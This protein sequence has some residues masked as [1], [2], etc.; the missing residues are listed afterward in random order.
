MPNIAKWRQ[1]P[2]VEFEQ[3]VKESKS[4]YELAEKIGYAKT[5]GGTQASLKKAVQERGLDTSHFTGQAW[6]KGQF[7][8]SSFQ[9]GTIKKN[10]KST[11]NPIIALRGRKCENCGLETWLDQPINL[12][13][14]H[15]DGDRSNNS[16]ENLILLC[17]NCHSYTETFCHKTEK[18]VID[19]EIFV[20]A[21][22]EN[23]T[24]HKALLQ[25]GLT[26]AAGN[27]TRARELISKYQLSHLY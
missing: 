21:L 3:M 7:D 11:L 15:K 5:G 16:L 14:H 22:R 2:E 6:N 17:L 1:I 19:D 23:K 20:Q 8:Y 9:K 12:E 26:A 13:I 10:G 24:I 27:Y 4:F 18:I 25:L